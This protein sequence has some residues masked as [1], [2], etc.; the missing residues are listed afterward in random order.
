MLVTDDAYNANPESMRA[1]LTAFADAAGP[2]GK[3]RQIVVL[4]DMASWVTT[5][6]ATMR[7]WAAS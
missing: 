7:R 1:A 2:G 4:G 3:G 6:R 5:S